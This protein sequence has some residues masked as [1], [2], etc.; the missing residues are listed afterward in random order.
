MKG[1]VDH[2]YPTTKV[3][4]APDP[5]CNSRDLLATSGDYLRIWNIQT[6][7]EAKLECVLKN[8]RKL[9]SWEGEEG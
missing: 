4:W 1:T 5:L 6:E 9:N 7:G 8:V 2:P 3:Q